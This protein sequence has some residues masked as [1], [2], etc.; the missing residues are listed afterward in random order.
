MYKL[1]ANFMPV[2]NSFRSVSDIQLRTM[3]QNCYFHHSVLLFRGS[4]TE[5]LF[6]IIQVINRVHHT[7]PVSCEIALIKRN[8]LRC[9]LS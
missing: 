4:S 3:A 6:L 8:E 2:K 1:T 5:R 7:V 9:I